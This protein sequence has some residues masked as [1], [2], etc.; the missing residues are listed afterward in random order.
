MASDITGT[1]KGTAGSGL[2]CL[3]ANWCCVS[4][5][6]RVYQGAI[7]EPDWAFKL[8]SGMEDAGKGVAIACLGCCIQFQATAL[9]SA[10]T[11]AAAQLVLWLLLQVLL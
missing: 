1:E 10:G 2:S 11:D 7:D 3:G 6:C 5:A 4:D 9:T 8:D